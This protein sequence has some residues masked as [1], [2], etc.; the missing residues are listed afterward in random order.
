MGDDVI[1]SYVANF[2]CSKDSDIENFLKQKAILFEKIGKSRTFLA[3]DEVFDI[4]GYFS[5]ALSILDVP[6]ILSNRKRKHLDGVSSK[7]KGKIVNKIPSILIGQLAKNDL[8]YGDFSGNR[9]L[10][11]CLSKILE[12]QK[13]LGGRIIMV[14]CK[15]NPNLID[16]YEHADFVLT[17]K[18][19]EKE[20]LLVFH[21]ILH[22][23]EITSCKRNSKQEIGE[24]FDN[25]AGNYKCEE[26][27][28]NN[29]VGKEL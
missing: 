1:E 11:I 3:V 15:K 25:Y 29:V 23:K 26:I 19:F 13:I 17:T 10:E 9:L 20:D 5:L 12:G 6:E 28:V 16:F 4:I 27:N 7:R 24:L 22:E 21:R 8:Y 2:Y 18:D 14:E